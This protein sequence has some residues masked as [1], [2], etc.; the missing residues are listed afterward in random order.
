MRSLP[1]EMQN[2]P[3]NFALANLIAC[4]VSTI[5]EAFARYPVALVQK[6]YQWLLAEVALPEVDEFRELGCV[7]ICE[8]SLFPIMIRAFG[9]VYKK[10]AHALKMHLCFSLNILL[11]VCFLI[12]NGKRLATPCFK[13]NL[14]RLAKT[15]PNIIDCTPIFREKFRKLQPCPD[16]I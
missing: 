6:L 7:A 3:Q 2:N 11:P 13:A 15:V 8:R 14:N 10:S 5:R 1:S 12:T 4:G 9:A 16:T